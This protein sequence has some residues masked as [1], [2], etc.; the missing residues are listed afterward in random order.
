MTYCSSCGAELKPDNKFCQ[1]CGQPL[2]APPAKGAGAVPVQ[3][4]ASGTA[5]HQIIYVQKLAAS[6]PGIGVAGFVLS[7]LG[8]SLPGLI[9]SWV[10]Y[11]KAK[12][13]GL[14]SG[15]CIA[16]IIIGA[17]GLVITV[18]VYVALSAAVSSVHTYYGG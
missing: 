2:D 3:Q 14:P 9:L 1:G 13:E 11:A 10:G 6:A 12:R 18:I 8:I 17:V 7:L 4:A 16:G 5:G 15:L